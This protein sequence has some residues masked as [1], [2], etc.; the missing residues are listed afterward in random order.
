LSFGFIFIYLILVMYFYLIEV[1]F[2]LIDMRWWWWRRVVDDLI[3][4]V[5]LRGAGAYTGLAGAY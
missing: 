1:D 5:G 4:T 2:A 3:I